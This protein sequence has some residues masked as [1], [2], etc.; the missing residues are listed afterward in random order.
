MCPEALRSAI[1]YAFNVIKVHLWN[2]RVIYF[3]RDL[4]RSSGPIHL[5]KQC[6]FLLQLP[7]LVRLLRSL[8]TLVFLLLLEGIDHSLYGLFYNQYSVFLL[9]S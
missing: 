7:Y 9:S 8:K 2:Q 3:I 1:L 6:Q 5:L 4:W